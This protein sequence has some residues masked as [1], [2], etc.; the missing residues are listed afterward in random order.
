[1]PGTKSKRWSRDVTEHSNALDL[2]KS[3]FDE[4]QPAGNRPVAEALGRG[5]SPAQ[6]RS[7]PLGHVDADVLHQPAGKNLPKV[8]RDKLE[9]A[10]DE[11]RKLFHR[12]ACVTRRR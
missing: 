2:E 11:L 5:E 1:M 7:L 9:T 4:G 8:R 12:D 3:V 6:E 10:N